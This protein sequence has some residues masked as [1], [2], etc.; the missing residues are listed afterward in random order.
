MFLTF[1]EIDRK[2]AEFMS[3]WGGAP[4]ADPV[5]REAI[6]VSW[7]YHDNAL[8]GV[9]LAYEEIKAA[10]Q[11]Q[12]NGGGLRLVPA[13][14]EIVNAHRTLELVRT[15]ALQKRL[16]LGVDLLKKIHTSLV[17]KLPNAQPGRYRKDI[18][19]HRAYYHEIAPPDRISGEMRK[20]TEYLASVPFKSAHPIEQAAHFQFRMMQIFPFSEISG[21]VT[22][23]ATNAILLHHGYLPA[24]LHAVDR[25]RYYESL[26]GSDPDTLQ[27]LILEAMDNSLDNAVRYFLGKGEAESARTPKAVGAR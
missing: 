3:R 13:F 12:V 7:I 17:D 1:G 18:P 25:Q 22:R 20:L 24:I 2:N 21:K 6:D 8:E 15:E 11:G 4:W 26:R 16:R 27:N 10:L 19:L 14:Q 9:V 23:L 5:F